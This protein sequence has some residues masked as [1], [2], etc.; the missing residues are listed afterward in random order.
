MIGIIVPKGDLTD[1][2]LEDNLNEYLK[3][4]LAKY[5][6]PKAYVFVEELPI[7]ENGKRDNGEIRKL[8]YSVS[9]D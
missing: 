9:V 3:K 4:N 2:V 5:K 8:L 6:L 1:E 7:L